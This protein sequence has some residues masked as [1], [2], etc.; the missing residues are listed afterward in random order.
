MT[1]VAAIIG[2][3][4]IVLSQTTTDTTVSI[5]GYKM[6]TDNALLAGIFILVA[7][8]LGGLVAFFKRKP[9]DQTPSITA[10]NSQVVV[11][12]AGAHLSRSDTPPPAAAPVAQEERVRVR[13]PIY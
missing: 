4:A 12:S 6:Q 2:V 8:L 7:G 9:K 3:V 1:V 10:V 5:A 11:G 13:E